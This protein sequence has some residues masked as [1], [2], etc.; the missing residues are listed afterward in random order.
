MASEREFVMLDSFDAYNDAR[1]E[2]V[3][4]QLE[5]ESA[6]A[7]GELRDEMK[8]RTLA[9]IERAARAGVTLAN[10]EPPKADGAKK[11]GRKSKEEQAAIDAAKANGHAEAME[12]TVPAEIQRQ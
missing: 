9:L 6:D 10:S 3:I 1:L 11:R 5:Q 8:R 2:A 12:S 7:L 4:D